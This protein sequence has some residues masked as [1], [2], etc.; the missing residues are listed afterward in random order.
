MSVLGNL[1]RKFKKWLVW[2]L[3]PMEN[4]APLNS[5]D[6]SCCA[7]I[8]GCRKYTQFPITGKHFASAPAPNTGKAPLSPHHAYPALHTHPAQELV[9]DLTHPSPKMA[10]DILVSR[11]GHRPVHQP[12]SLHQVCL[13]PPVKSYLYAKWWYEAFSSMPVQLSVDSLCWNTAGESPDCLH[14]FQKH[15]PAC[16]QSP[17]QWGELEPAVGLPW[18]TAA[19]PAGSS[20][21]QSILNSQLGD[22][23]RAGRRG[24]GQ[25]KSCGTPTPEHDGGTARPPGSSARHSPTRTDPAPRQPADLPSSRFMRKWWSLCVLP[26]DKPWYPPDSEAG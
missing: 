16:L 21:D 18:L 4:T 2:V 11:D 24:S 17:G 8:N 19:K 23:L 15:L 25:G 3:P 6:N 9:G 7:C 5:T 14:R 1:Y 22:L 10:G 13:S 20:Q 26:A 12:L